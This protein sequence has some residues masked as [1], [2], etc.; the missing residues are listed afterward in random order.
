MSSEVAVEMYGGRW[1]RYPAYKD[2][3]VEWL[4]EVPEH[5]HID[6]L[7]WSVEGCNNGVWGDEPNGEDD[8]PCIRV[9]DFNRE[10]LTVSTNKL[11]LRAISAK[12]RNVR[13][14]Q[15]NDLLLEKSGGGEKQL[16]GA[17]I[18]FNHEFEAV[19]SNF[20]SRMPVAEGISSRFQFYF[21]AHLYMNRVSQPQRLQ[22]NPPQMDQFPGIVDAS[23]PAG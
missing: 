3:G 17:V 18:Q 6:R 14:L 21:H 1:K 5:W 23:P 19:S 20:I 12:D 16:V 13:L 2:S 4:G 22:P 10:D 7:K 15:K 11:T 9:A 8:L